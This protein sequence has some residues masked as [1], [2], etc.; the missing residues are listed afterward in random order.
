M[1]QEQTEGRE[2]L[3]VTI[4]FTNHNPATIWNRLAVELGRE[5]THREACERVRLILRDS[6]EVKP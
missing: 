5:P 6:R 2:G 3:I 1:R 4:T